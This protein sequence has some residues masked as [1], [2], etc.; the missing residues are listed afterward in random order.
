MG[1]AVEKLKACLGSLKN[2]P[3]GKCIIRNTD[4]LTLSG[5]M[6]Y[7]RHSPKYLE[8]IKWFVMPR[9]HQRMALNGCHRDAGHQDKKRALSLA[10]DR[11]LWPGVQEVAENIVCDCK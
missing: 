9:A 1:S 6:L 7:Y 2:Q 4:K 8:E 5:G 11:F 3:E 10:T